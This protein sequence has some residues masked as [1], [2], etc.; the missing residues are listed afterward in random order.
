[1]RNSLRLLSR[2]QLLSRFR[3]LGRF[4]L[5]SRDGAGHIVLE[6]ESRTNAKPTLKVVVLREP[7]GVVAALDLAFGDEVDSSVR[8]P[9]AGNSAG[10]SVSSANIFSVA[11]GGATPWVF[12]AQSGAEVNM[13]ARQLRRV[14]G[15]AGRAT[16]VCADGLV[17]AGSGHD[18][19]VN[20]PVAKEVCAA[21]L[22]AEDQR[23]CVPA[24]DGYDM[25]G[26]TADVQEA[27]LRTHE[28]ELVRI[29]KERLVRE[30]LRDSG[31]EG[32][33]ND[34][35]TPVTEEDLVAHVAQ[36]PAT[37]T[38]KD[39]IGYDLWTLAGRLSRRYSALPNGDHPAIVEIIHG[40]A[41]RTTGLP[42]ATT[43]RGTARQANCF[44]SWHMAA[45]LAGLLA[46]QRARES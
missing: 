27:F 9:T 4:R 13:C 26:L 7:G 41:L 31:K 3:L 29:V 23:G 18:S 39:A 21:G 34:F 17:V 24:V 20:S 11:V 25:M 19:E 43:A 35:E 38:L 32:Y 28:P 10:Y 42:V 30:L 1:M 8:R 36:L 45:P 12:V 40:D 16:S 22:L 14:A 44:L 33:W 6:L 37:L 46:V 5:L 2:F 15:V